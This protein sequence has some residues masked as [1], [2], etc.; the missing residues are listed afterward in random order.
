[1]SEK[2][3]KAVAFNNKITPKQLFADLLND[4]SIVEAVVIS[5]KIDKEGEYSFICESTTMTMM[6]M[7]MAEKALSVTASMIVLGDMQDHQ[8]F[9]KE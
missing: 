3:V 1:M 9:S 4:D 7:C 8:D 5:K 6:D 2:V